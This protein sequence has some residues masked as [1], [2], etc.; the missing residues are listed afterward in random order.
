MGARAHNTH[1]DRYRNRRA[2]D[3]TCDP[4]CAACNAAE[5]EDSTSEFVPVF[6][7]QHLR[8]ELSATEPREYLTRG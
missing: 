3:D 5:M 7:A 6:H 8:H 2:L 1:H 4:A